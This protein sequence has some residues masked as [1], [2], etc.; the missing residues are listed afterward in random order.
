M[1]LEELKKLREELNDIEFVDKKNKVRMFELID[2]IEKEGG[3][4]EYDKEE[5]LQIMEDEE[6]VGK[7]LIEMGESVGEMIKENS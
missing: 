1:N 6:D 4:S 7:M 5:L 3:L 2:K